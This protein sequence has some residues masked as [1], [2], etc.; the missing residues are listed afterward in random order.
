MRRGRGGR[1]RRTDLVSK[2]TL[3]STS[4]LHP[5]EAP[6]I[7]P[8][9]SRHVIVHIVSLCSSCSFL[10]HYS[11]PFRPFIRRYL[12]TCLPAYLPRIHH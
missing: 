8:R 11:I 5:L 6:G 1:R 10:H 4:G 9:H 7:S 2:K 12:A 3:R